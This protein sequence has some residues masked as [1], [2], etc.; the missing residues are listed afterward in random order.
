MSKGAVITIDG[1]S[2]AGKSTIGR[3]L[4]ARLNYTYLDT[5]AMYRAVGLKVRQAGIDLDD[6]VDR[7][8]LTELLDSLD[9]RLAPA[10]G[11]GR[12]TRVFLDNIEV[13]AA[14]RTA[15]M[16]MVAS[17]VSAEPAVR[18]KLTEM[19]QQ[20]GRAGG[21]VAEGRDTGTVV[22]P[23][24]EYKFYLD[25]GPEERARRRW[26]QLKEKGQLVDREELLAQIRKRDHDDRSR[27][28]APLTP[29][30]DAVIIDSSAMSIDEVVESLLARIKG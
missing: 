15:E 19:Q 10:Q 29:A 9:L 25:A 6:P 7:P 5:G 20:L 12:D 30:A 23:R 2:G 26:E 22:F 4:A 24:A 28:L 16:G 27:A 18:K 8:R 3:L 21:V 1:P 13:S 17:R 14:I 11:E